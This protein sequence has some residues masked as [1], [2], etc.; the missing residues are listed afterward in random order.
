MARNDRG[1]DRDRS[2]RGRGWRPRTRGEDLSRGVSLRRFEDD[3]PSGGQVAATAATGGTDRNP[4]GRGTPATLG[5]KAGVM[6]LALAGL[7]KAEIA[8]RLRRNR[9]TI[10][11]LLD[12]EEYEKLKD[13]AEDVLRRHIPDFAQ[14]WDRA[15]FLAS[16]KGRHEPARDA[17]TSLGVVAPPTAAAQIRVG[18]GVQVINGALPGLGDAARSSHGASIATV[19]VSEP[20]TGSEARSD[21]DRQAG[22]GNSSS[23][24]TTDRAPTPDDR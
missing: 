19:V 4:R 12:E 20:A 14:D 10:D 9:K 3:P 6:A 16:L 23:E 5:E 18:V 22:S 11:R 2:G 17:L 21:Q 24:T 7:S 8:R 1:G 13:A 15:S